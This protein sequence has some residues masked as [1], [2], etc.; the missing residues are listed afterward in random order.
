MMD[1][2]S[3]RDDHPLN[4]LGSAEDEHDDGRREQ[5]P[6][7]AAE[8]YVLV[9]DSQDLPNGIRGL[10]PGQLLLSSRA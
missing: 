2:G 5:V 1:A 4:V 7:V 3:D 6:A 10:A 9:Y 8:V